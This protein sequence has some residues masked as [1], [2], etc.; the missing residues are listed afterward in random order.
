MT[1]EEVLE[2]VER[3][4]GDVSFWGETIRDEEN[5]KNIKMYA[6]VATK[7]VEKLSEVYCQTKGR[8]EDS[9]KPL[10]KEA[11][12]ALGTIKENVSCLEDLAGWLSPEEWRVYCHYANDSHLVSV[13]ATCEGEITVTDDKGKEY[14][15]DYYDKVDVCN[16]KKEEDDHA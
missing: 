8:Y 11:K 13:N 15:F 5:A 3:I 10:F 9:S 12:K 14:K 7:M 4:I 1:N 2:I 16:P 6:Y